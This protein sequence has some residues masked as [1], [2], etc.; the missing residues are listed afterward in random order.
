MKHWLFDLY[1]Q[2]FIAME[3]EKELQ[4]C[5]E[6]IPDLMKKIGMGQTTPIKK[7]PEYILFEAQKKFL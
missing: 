3:K 1:T 7:A 2:N 6:I 5:S 4:G